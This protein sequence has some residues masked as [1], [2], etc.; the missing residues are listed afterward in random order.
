MPVFVEKEEVPDGYFRLLYGRAPQHTFTRT[1]NNSRLLEV[2]PE[3]EVW[4]NREIADLYRL[5][6]GSYVVLVN[7]SG[8]RSNRIKVRITERIRQD[9]VYMVHGFGRED[10]RL[11]KAFHKGANDNGLLSDYISDPIMGSTG[12]QVNY[13]TFVK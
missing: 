8:I 10:R 5:E 1:V 13:V 11:S 4:I 3:N 9:C 12:S 2:C 6:N 7:Q